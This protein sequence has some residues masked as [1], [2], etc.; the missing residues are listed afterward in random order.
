MKTRASLK[1]LVNIGA[2]MILSVLML[3]S[4]HSNLLVYINLSSLITCFLFAGSMYIFFIIY[5]LASV[6]YLLLYLAQSQS[7]Y[8]ILK[9]ILNIQYTGC[10]HKLPQNDFFIKANCAGQNNF[11]LSS[12]LV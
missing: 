10:A 8:D 9:T 5:F 12:S 1:Y 4:V 11:K 6:L 3:W 7:L 2:E